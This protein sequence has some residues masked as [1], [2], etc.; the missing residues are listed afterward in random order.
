[1]TRQHG[2]HDAAVA[3][4]NLGLGEGGGEEKAGGGVERRTR[5]GDAEGDG[6]VKR[7][8]GGGRR[9]EGAGVEGVNTLIHSHLAEFYDFMYRGGGENTVL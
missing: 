7:E 6:K 4:E 1:M 3:D 2:H 8:E 9:E 5:D